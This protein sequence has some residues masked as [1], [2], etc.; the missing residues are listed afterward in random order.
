[1]KCPVCKNSENHP[2]IDIQTNGFNEEII[3]CDICGTVWSVNHG[4]TEIVKDSQERSFLEA[5]SDS[6]ES[7]DSSWTV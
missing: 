4:A 6:V 3:T 2:E 1:M 7:N 5:A